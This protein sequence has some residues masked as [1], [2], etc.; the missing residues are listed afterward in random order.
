MSEYKFALG[1]F[2]SV[3][4]W[5]AKQDREPQHL[6]LARET[7]EYFNGPMERRYL[8][9]PGVDCDT[10]WYYESELVKP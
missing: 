8:I 4:V 5:D 6:I 1:A 7:T 3:R 9:R 10:R 2:V